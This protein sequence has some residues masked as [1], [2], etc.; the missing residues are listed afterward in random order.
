MKKHVRP[1]VPALGALVL[2]CAAYGFITWQQGRSAKAKEPGPEDTAV[3]MTDL[4]GLSA[5][6][7]KT[8]DKSLSFT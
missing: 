7:W 2:L 1:M 3:Y 6:S 5:L 8:D 4:P